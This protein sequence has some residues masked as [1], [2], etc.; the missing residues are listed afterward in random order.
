MQR[1]FAFSP[2]DKIA[3]HFI[4][5]G[6]QIL[7]IVVASVILLSMIGLEFLHMQYGNSAA[8]THSAPSSSSELSTG[9]LLP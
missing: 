5:S 4:L 3:Q 7:V 6:K 2:A 9:M 1:P 8:V